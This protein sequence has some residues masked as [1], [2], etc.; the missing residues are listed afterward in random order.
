MSIERGR[1]MIKVS[2]E[3]LAGPA[4]TGIDE[5]TARTLARE[6]LEFMDTTGRVAML[7]PGGGNFF[8]GRS[9]GENITSTERAE[10]DYDGMVGTARNAVAIAEALTAEGAVGVGCMLNME[11]DDL[12]RELRSYDDFDRHKA[13]DLLGMGRIIV[14]GGG[15]RLPF[16]CTDL[17]CVMFGGML[18]AERIM[19][20]TKEAGVYSSDPRQP[21]DDLELFR[22]IS[23]KEAAERNLNV[24]EPSAWV[25]ARDEVRIPINVYD[26]R[27]QGNI[28]DAF[29]GR[30]GTYISSDTSAS[31]WP[32]DTWQSHNKTT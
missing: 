12:P 24:L 25:I 28:I 13:R 30:T 32:R 15:T 27:I 8:R 4:V 21:S 9:A 16:C 22:T 3:Q 7:L 10:A 11:Q 20:G 18:G 5:A 26:M 29:Q 23:F 19:K 2:G 6:V 14:I 1:V 17:S 31:L